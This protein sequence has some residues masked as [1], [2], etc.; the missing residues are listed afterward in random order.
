MDGAL[1][2]KAMGRPI[3]T[4]AAETNRLREWRM[5]LGLT[6]EQL[7]EL[8]NTTTATIQRLES[9]ARELKV[10][11]LPRFALALGIRPVDL[12]PGSA[13]TSTEQRELLEIFDKLDTE[14]QRRLVRIAATF[15]GDAPEL[16]KIA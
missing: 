2:H 10:S 7:A 8:A 4:R 11:Q 15:R 13:K 14:E 9:G 12:L 3:S 16:K 6:M 1:H 5:H